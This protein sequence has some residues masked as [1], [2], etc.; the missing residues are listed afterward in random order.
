MPSRTLRAPALARAKRSPLRSAG[1]LLQRAEQAA[2]VG[3]FAATEVLAKVTGST[4][5][6]QRASDEF[7]TYLKLNAQALRLP[8][9]AVDGLKTR[10]AKMRMKL[11]D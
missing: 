2:A 4:A 11:K 8:S 3:R 7:E 10:F 9:S 6:R 1:N 5:L